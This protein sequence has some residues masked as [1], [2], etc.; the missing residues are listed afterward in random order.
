MRKGR[1][2]ALGTT[3]ISGEGKEVGKRGCG[4]AAKD[5]DKGELSCE[6]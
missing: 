2:E 1:K 3:N 4:A 5:G 6:I